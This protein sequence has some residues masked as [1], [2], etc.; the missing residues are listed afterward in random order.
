MK[1]VFILTN[2]FSSLKERLDFESE[3]KYE[4]FFQDKNVNLEICQVS[5]TIEFRNLIKSKSPD[6]VIFHECSG[7]IIK[8]C[9]K[10]MEIIFKK[11]FV[12]II[13]EKMNNNNASLLIKGLEK[14]YLNFNPVL[15]N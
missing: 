14:I 8:E 13:I 15:L 7:T 11:Q 5:D 2:K 9:I 6:L 12:I 10:I 3:I 1:N 4:K